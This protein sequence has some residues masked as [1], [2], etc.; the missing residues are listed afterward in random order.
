MIDED[1][2]DRLIACL[3][4]KIAEQEFQFSL[5]RKRPDPVLE[6]EVAERR[7]RLQRLQLGRERRLHQADTIPLSPP[8]SFSETELV[9]LQ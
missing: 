7:K 8:G 6:R 5:S 1:A 4:T 3:M 2:V 9:Y